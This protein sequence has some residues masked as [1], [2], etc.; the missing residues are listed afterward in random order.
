M[1]KNNPVLAGAGIAKAFNEQSEWSFSP[2]G[3]IH[4]K[5]QPRTRRSG[6]CQII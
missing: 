1:L 2:D 4:V 6:D 3:E 5:E